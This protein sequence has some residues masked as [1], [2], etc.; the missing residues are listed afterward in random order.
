LTQVLGL[1][2]LFAGIAASVG[3]VLLRMNAARGAQRAQLKWL[4]YAALLFVLTFIAQ[5]LLPSW[6]VASAPIVDTAL[7]VVFAITFAAIPVTIGL[8]ILR[9]RLYD[10]DLVTNRTLVYGATSAAIAATFWVGLVALQP[11]LSGVTSANEL[12]VAASTLASFALFQPIRRR[13]QN[14]VD[15]RFD[16]SRYDAARTLEAFADRLRD[17]VDLDALRA[18]LVGVVQRTMAPAHASLWLRERAR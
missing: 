16:R 12:A 11:L 10:I 17:E 5:A 13:V 14:A 6:L 3:T 9:Y 7:D 4:A 15:R 8:A 1:P 18:D 2:V